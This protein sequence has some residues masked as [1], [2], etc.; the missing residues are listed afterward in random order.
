LNAAY[1]SGVLSQETFERRVDQVL[2]ARLLDP[3]GSSAI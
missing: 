3:F 1:A 2:K